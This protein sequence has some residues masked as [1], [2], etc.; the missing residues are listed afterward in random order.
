RARRRHASEDF[1]IVTCPNCSKKYDIDPAKLAGRTS[2]IARCRHCG[3]TISLKAEGPVPA[4]EAGTATTPAVCEAPA[5]TDAPLATA[6]P[7]A[8]VAPTKPEPPAGAATM[9]L[10]ADASP[11]PAPEHALPGV[12]SWPPA[13]RGS[14]SVLE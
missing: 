13:P 14:R 3:A 6:A 9:R 5:V 12:P 7:A 11:L 1:V 2:A 10:P 4:E 8:T